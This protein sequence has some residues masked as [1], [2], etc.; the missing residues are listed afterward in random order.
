MGYIAVPLS[1]IVFVVHMYIHVCVTHNCISYTCTVHMHA[2]KYTCT[3]RCG[4]G[5]GE[6]HTCYSGI[7]ADNKPVQYGLLWHS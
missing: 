6:S 2:N 1:S 3:C 5:E 4:Y 7:Y